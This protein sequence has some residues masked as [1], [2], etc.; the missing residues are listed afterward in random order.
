MKGKSK[1]GAESAFSQSTVTETLIGSFQAI[2]ECLAI[3]CDELNLAKAKLDE[4]R[5]ALKSDQD[6]RSG[7]A[8]LQGHCLEVAGFLEQLQG[9][10][11]AF[12]CSP[13][14]FTQ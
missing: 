2:D 6:L 13:G 11:R 7:H 5:T 10:R 14:R 8:Q 4:L 9:L 12:A 1:R 3:S